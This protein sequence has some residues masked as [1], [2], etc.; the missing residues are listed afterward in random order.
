MA[1]VGIVTTPDLPLINSDTLD[2]RMIAS[3][4]GLVSFKDSGDNT[5]D[6]AY[7]LPVNDM[8]TIA[9]EMLTHHHL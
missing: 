3:T 9:L 6:W 4:I 1:S 5:G 2:G 8:R 7:A